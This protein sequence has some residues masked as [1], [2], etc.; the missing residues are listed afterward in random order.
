[1]VLLSHKVEFDLTSLQLLLVQ[2]IFTCSK[3][4]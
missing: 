4:L 2:P 3:T 1:V